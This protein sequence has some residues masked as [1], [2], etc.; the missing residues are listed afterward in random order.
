MSVNTEGGAVVLDR[1]VIARRYSSALAEGRAGVSAE[2]GEFHYGF[3]DAII[4]KRVYSL[5]F[6]ANGLNDTG[7]RIFSEVTDIALPKQLGA[8]WERLREW[9]GLSVEVD[10]KN[11]AWHQVALQRRL[12][13]PK[14][15]LDAIIWASEKVEAGF[16]DLRKVGRET[17]LSNSEGKGWNLSARGSHLTTLVPFFRAKIAYEQAAELCAAVVD[18]SG[19]KVSVKDIPHAALDSIH[20]GEILDVQQQGLV[21]IQKTGRDDTDVVRHNALR[22]SDKVQKGDV[23]DIRYQDGKGV[24]GGLAKVADLSR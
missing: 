9:A 23:V 7:K 1:D 13:E 3:A 19:V 16:N 14:V 4:E 18:I 20:A 12:I 17:W 24:V 2:P 22:L 5:E 10:N 6:L 8:T 11:R 15:G 21:V